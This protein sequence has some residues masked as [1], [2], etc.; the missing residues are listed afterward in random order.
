MCSRTRPC[1]VCDKDFFTTDEGVSF[2]L[3]EAGDVDHDEDAD[4]VPYMIE[5]ES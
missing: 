4:H 1:F 5:V 2:H 3:D